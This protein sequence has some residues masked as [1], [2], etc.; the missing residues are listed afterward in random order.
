MSRSPHR[1]RPGSSLRD[2]VATLDDEQ[3]A[4]MLGAVPCL[5][6]AV[7]G[8]GPLAPLWPLGQ[9]TPGPL[10][11]GGFERLFASSPVVE[12]IVAA[13][14]APALALAQAASWYDGS[15]SVDQA[16]SEASTLT[17]AEIV[18]AAQQL[19]DRL[20]TV[21]G[22]RF[23]T[24]HPTAEEH[25]VLPGIPAEWSLTH[26]RTDDLAAR[27]RR[28]GRD[29]PARKHE[30]TRALVSALRDPDVLARALGRLPAD[31][32]RVFALLVEHGPQRVADLGVPHWPPY[33]RHADGGIAV[34]L[35]HALV[36][37]DYDE[38]QCFVWLDVLVGLNGGQL[39]GDAFPRPRPPDPVALPGGTVALPPVLEQLD[40]LL[41]H[42]R[43]RPAP[44]LASGALGVRPVRAA[45]KALGMSGPEV[46]MLAT[47]AAHIGLL[48]V[49]E[50]GTSGRGRNRTTSYQWA[51]TALVE[52]W[53]DTSPATQWTHLVHAWRRST[54]LAE[55]EGLPERFEPDAIRRDA[56]A[57]AARSAWL[58][59]LADLPPGSGVAADDMVE[60]AGARFP[61]LLS[62]EVVTGLLAVGRFLG[63]V[64]SSGSVGLTVAGRAVLDGVEALEA[65]LPAPS[66]E[67]VVQADLTVMTPPDVAPEITATLARWAELESSA[68]ARVYRITERRL[69]SAL[70][71]GADVDDV[72]GWFKAHSRVG[73]PQNVEYLIRDVARRRGQI[74]AGIAASY[75]RCDD[76][77][78]L[79][80]AVSVRRAKL[81]LLAPTVG[82]SSLDREALLAALADAGVAAV[83][84]DAAGVVVDAGAADAER[85][86]YGHRGA[87]LPRLTRVASIDEQVA[88]LSVVDQL[89]LVDMST[90]DAPDDE[91]TD[92]DD[93]VERLRRRSRGEFQDA[94]GED[95]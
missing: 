50:T 1:V 4:G 71:A 67:V 45:A 13:L 65:V 86:G 72:L 28:L 74:R 85:V 56:T 35:D 5:A 17:D 49:V 20:L 94:S 42:W 78:L 88:R 52:A 8:L 24:L 95:A 92:W 29:V 69:T 59:L 48:G 80:R 43:A 9:Q 26:T 46:G 6:D 23:V 79:T 18:A 64:P 10:D 90:P 36:G 14:D 12:F 22:D 34:L 44:A 77:A 76:P 21:P 51:P 19:H 3:L 37:V 16:R 83:G 33:G 7:A 61:L 62:S 15:L 82:V 11:R 54:H 27:L 73:V 58:L 30:R 57:A 75:L 41:D 66:T 38:Q 31:A 40:A 47:L 89:Q 87:G 70:A 55:I 53:R 32:A 84:E 68:G 93:V 81:R 25:V 2:R 60:A 91:V 39:F 63:L